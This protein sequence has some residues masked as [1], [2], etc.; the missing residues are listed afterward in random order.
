MD[1]VEDRWVHSVFL[2]GIFKYTY[3]SVRFHERYTNAKHTRA[4]TRS[5]NAIN[6]NS[7]RWGGFGTECDDANVCC[8][9]GFSGI[10]ALVQNNVRVWSEMVASSAPETNHP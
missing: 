2:S 1:G 4:H 3:W 9:A 7:F 10:I 6:Y 8:V 5:R